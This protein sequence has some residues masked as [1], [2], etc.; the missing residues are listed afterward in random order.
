[1]GRLPSPILLLLLQEVV[2][3]TTGLI[4]EIV[5][6]PRGP[7]VQS[8]GGKVEPQ[9]ESPAGFKASPVALSGAGTATL[10]C[11]PLAALL[12]GQGA[13]SWLLAVLQATA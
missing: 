7:C 9:D 2:E 3:N 8:S 4:P 10:R 5:P 6:P 1:M 11:L 12:F 13:L